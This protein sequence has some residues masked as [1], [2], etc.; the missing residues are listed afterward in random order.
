MPASAMA[1][2]SCPKFDF[3]KDWCMKLDRPCRIDQPGCVLRGK[4]MVA[5]DAPPAASRRRS[6]R[7]AAGD[8]RAAP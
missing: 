6:R 3:E 2:F 7:P 5:A 8:G 1:S 4:A